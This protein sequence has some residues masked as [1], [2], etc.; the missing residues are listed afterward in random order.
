VTAPALLLLD[1]EGVL[2]EHVDPYILGAEQVQPVPGALEAVAR[3]TR[4]GIQ[5]AVVTNQ[6]CI[7]SGLASRSFVDETNRRLVEWIARAGGSV[8]GVWVCP[9]RP[10][11]RCGCRK[12]APGLL[13]QAIAATA[14]DPADAWMVGDHETDV[15]AGWAAGC[16]QSIQV[17]T[18][19]Q[20][21]PCE[22]A[23]AVHP[24]LATLVSWLLGGAAPASRPGNRHAGAD[25]PR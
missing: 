3:L 19:R 7:G 21:G 20:A 16:A 6:S 11:D 4:A 13:V 23:S 22:L 9:H 2:L 15:R 14:V 18:G 17:L 25:V 12:P 10:I 5:A 24:S 8:A 1:R